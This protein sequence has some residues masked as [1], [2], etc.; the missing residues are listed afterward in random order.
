MRSHWTTALRL[1]SCVSVRE[2]RD[3][4]NLVLSVCTL[5]EWQPRATPHGFTT[6]STYDLHKLHD[7]HTVHIA[8][9]THTHMR[10]PRG[11]ACVYVHPASRHGLASCD[12]QRACHQ[13]TITGL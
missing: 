10:P 1:Y 7:L 5:S 3:G 4:C 6:P 13:P 12:A 9:S 8:R 11:V 2:K